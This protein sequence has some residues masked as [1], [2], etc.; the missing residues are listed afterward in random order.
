MQELHPLPEEL[1]TRIQECG[2]MGDNLVNLMPEQT[3]K[4]LSFPNIE[5]NSNQSMLNFISKSSEDITKTVNF[6]NVLPHHQ[7]FG[8]SIEERTNFDDFISE[9]YE[10]NNIFPYMEHYL[11]NS[12]LNTFRTIGD[13]FDDDDYG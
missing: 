2:D 6:G 13:I 9:D 12:S 1:P 11:H 7:S 3:V 5:E 10:F 8:V 4:H